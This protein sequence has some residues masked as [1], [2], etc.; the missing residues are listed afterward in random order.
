MSEFAQQINILN[1]ATIQ[2]L[3]ENIAFVLMMDNYNIK[4][5]DY[6]DLKCEIKNNNRFI[7][8]TRMA[9]E[10]LR[11]TQILDMYLRKEGILNLSQITGL[12]DARHI[13][14]YIA[15][16]FASARHRDIKER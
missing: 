8:D 7:D 2:K 5:E 9:V 1:D 11:K 6:L 13:M 15:T 16:Y 12:K 14:D 3:K 10:Y 4:I